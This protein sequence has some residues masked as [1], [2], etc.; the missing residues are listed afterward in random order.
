[1]KFQR[2]EIKFIGMWSHP[3]FAILSVAVLSYGGGA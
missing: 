1:M 2:A 3:L